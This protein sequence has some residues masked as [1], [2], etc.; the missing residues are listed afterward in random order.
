M[1]KIDTLQ[2][3][4]SVADHQSFTEA[5]AQHQQTP[6]ALSKQVSQLEQKL[7][8][9]LFT[10]T[11]RKVRLTEF[12]EELY[13]KA[14][15]ILQHHKSLDDWMESRDE[16]V[17]GNLKLCAQHG[18]MFIETIYPWLDEFCQLYPEINLSF[19]VNEGVLDIHKDQFD[20]YWGISEYLGQKYTGLKKR[21]LWRSK[22]GIYAAPT[23]L[24]KYGIPT[25]IEELDGHKVIGYLHNQPNNVLVYKDLKDTSNKPFDVVELDSSI[26]T[27]AGLTELAV[28]GLGLVNAAADQRDVKK[29]L[30]EGKLL[31]VLEAFWSDAAEV[32][33][34]YHQS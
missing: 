26:Q 3:F 15:D 22:Y 5:A 11:T 1:F 30:N 12:G 20:I 19:D 28:N 6:M 23:Y 2:A 8:E 14:F 29:Y 33:I 18:D 17:S 34:Y 4:V 24:A 7:G 21:F 27:V 16:K 25:T 9:A 10:R 32:F 31:P 13:N